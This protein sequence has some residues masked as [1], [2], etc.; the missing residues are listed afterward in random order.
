[1]GDVAKEI[2]EIQ[3]ARNCPRL[4]YVCNVYA[5]DS[6]SIEVEA[7]YDLPFQEIVGMVSKKAKTVDIFLATNGTSGHQGSKLT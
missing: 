4:M 3:K 6:E 1:M 7:V 5:K 2:S